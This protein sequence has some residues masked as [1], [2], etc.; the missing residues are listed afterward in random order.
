MTLTIKDE[1][2]DPRR[3]R[4]KCAICRHKQC[5]EIDQDYLDWKPMTEIVETYR[6]QER[7][8]YRHVKA[9]GLWDKKKENRK[10]LYLRIMEKADLSGVSVMEALNAGK[11]LEMVEGKISTTQIIEEKRPSMEEINRRIERIQE[12]ESALPAD[13]A[14]AVLGEEYYE[15]AKS[16]RE[17]QADILPETLARL[18]AVR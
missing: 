9:L 18:K 16:L 2:S 4:R 14:K 6:V 13:K 3:H 5:E 1:E 17:L 12:I 7:S 11:L 10:H 8:L 15:R